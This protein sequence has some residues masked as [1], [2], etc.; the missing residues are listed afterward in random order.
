MLSYQSLIDKIPPEAVK[1]EYSLHNKKLTT[2]LEETEE[3]Y[4]VRFLSDLDHLTLHW[5][6]GLPKPKDWK[7]PVGL[8]NITSP[9]GTVKFDDKAAQSPFVEITSDFSII[10]IL[11]SKSNS[12]FQVNFVIKREN[13][14]F[15]NNGQNYSVVIREPEGPKVDAIG[16]VKDLVIEI[17]RSEMEYN[18]WTLMHRFNM[19][20]RWIERINNDIQGLAWIFVWMRYSALRKLD[21]QR[22]YNTRPS[23]LARS[24]QNLTYTITNAIKNSKLNGLVNP[25]ILLRGILGTMGKGGGNGQRIRDQILEIMHRNKIMEHNNY[26]EQWHQ[27]LHNNTTPDDIGIC[28]ATIAFN[29]TNSLSRFYEV[30]NKNGITRERLRSF[31]RPITMEPFYAPHLINDLRDYLNLLKAVHGSTDLNSAVN[32][33]RNFLPS[34]LI[35]KLNNLMGNL[36]HWDKIGLMDQT[37]EIRKHLNV[38][39]DRGGIEQYR[40]II[41]LDMGLEAYTRQICEEIIHLDIQF[42][43][44]C[45]E[46]KILIQNVQILS[47]DPELESASQDFYILNDRIIDTVPN[48]KESALIFKAS[49]DRLQRVLGTFVDVYSDL[50]GTKAQVLGNEFKVE[51]FF[52]DLFAE[53]IIRGSLLFAVSM[54]LKKID[55]HLRKYCDFKSWQIISPKPQALGKFLQV[56]SLHSVAYTIYK[57]STVLICE[58]VT[59]EEEIP[60]NVVAVISCTELDALAHVSVRAR[61][62]KVLLVV[63]FDATEIQKLSVYKNTWVKVTMTS[64]GINVTQ[65]QK[66]IEE[67]KETEARV[68][69]IPLGL[70]KIVIKADEFEEGRTGAKGNNCAFLKKTLP[71]HIGVPCSIALPYGTCEYIMSQEENAKTNNEIQDLLQKLIGK[72]HNTEA[73]KILDEI[74]SKIMKLTLNDEDKNIIQE[75]LTDIGCH[76]DKWDLAWKAIK[77]VWASKYNERVYL[78]IVKA[79]ISI[80]SVVMCVLCQEVIT[81]EYAYVLHT[82]NPFTNNSNEIYGELVLGLGETLVGA[83]EG[84]AFSFIVNKT[85]GKYE[86]SAFPNKSVALRG[87]GFIFRSDSNSEDLPGFAGAGLFDSFVMEE[88]REFRLTYA[89]DNLIAN[90][91]FRNLV[92]EKLNEVGKI[93]EE[94]YGGEPQDIEGVI[95]NNK[96]FVVQARPQV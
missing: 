6:I 46:L 11:F 2:V 69:K 33:C 52:V 74:K 20:N 40:E 49:C 10:E 27:K 43:Y 79:Q 13:I 89:E 48:D 86:I 31:E 82:K 25:T 34:D 26:Y 87:N 4:K 17:I 81:G 68:V 93:V 71:K 3:E 35:Q 78:S 90:R 95:S 73:R 22:N 41:Y 72:E 47:Q 57:E 94:F 24:N 61:N 5:G 9:K 37:L 64:N 50:I 83:F 65:T 29:E 88:P 70:S 19:C 67:T 59:G 18:S 16:E 53:E 23:E 12:P 56:E 75:Y 91:E 7:C 21:W 38:Y 55:G 85:T 39:T 84:R 32:T 62:N 66:V 15:N 28:E 1:K 45:R 60:D 92:I 96:V 36:Q 80:N 58:K 77:S 63:C 76:E 42:K 14:W 51:K 54:V 8:E 30:L 44:L